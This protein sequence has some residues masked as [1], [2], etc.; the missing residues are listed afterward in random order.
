[1]NGIARIVCAEEPQPLSTDNRLI[2]LLLASDD[3]QDRRLYIM[4]HPGGLELAEQQQL[5]LHG[6]PQNEAFFRM[7]SQ[8]KNEYTAVYA[9][10][11]VGADDDAPDVYGHLYETS[12]KVLELSVLNRAMASDLATVTYPDGRTE[13][14]RHEDYEDIDISA[15]LRCQNI[16]RSLERHNQML[17]ETWPP[18]VAEPNRAHELDVHLEDLWG[19][20]VK[21]EATR[22]QRA[23]DHMT[24]PNN[25]KGRYEIELSP[26]FQ[27]IPDFSLAQ[28]LLVKQLKVPAKMVLPAR[29]RPTASVSVSRRYI[30]AERKRVYPYTA[31]EARERGELR[32]YR[33]SQWMNIACVEAMKTAISNNDDHYTFDSAA[34]LAE[35][36]GKFSK[37]RIGYVLGCIVHH[38]DWDKRYSQQ[39]REWAARFPLDMGI[40][41]N[42]HPTRIDALTKR[43]REAIMPTKDK[44]RNAPGR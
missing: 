18:L 38:A 31:H 43:Y 27:T 4:A 3:P 19:G 6:T 7:S 36:F 10:E 40:G 34:A 21:Y 42:A 23:L 12:Y 15:A 26:Q 24:E 32:E 30:D 2:E 1:V 9:V 25:P 33:I 29:N 8:H 13:I 37:E 35:L 17:G 39:N 16:P 41:C 22:V 5:Y 14:V 44:K 28:N 11:L 20:L